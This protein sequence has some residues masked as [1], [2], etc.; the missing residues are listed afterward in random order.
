MR[1]T[2][3]YVFSAVCKLRKNIL[4]QKLNNFRLAFYNCYLADIFL[5]RNYIRIISETETENKNPC[6]APV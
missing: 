1:P 2:E 4:F 6:R 5:S 3:R